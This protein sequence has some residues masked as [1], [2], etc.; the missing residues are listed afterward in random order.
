MRI[1]T[2][3]RLRAVAAVLRMFR[4]QTA[5]VHRLPVILQTFEPLPLPLERMVEVSGRKFTLL[6]CN[7]SA[8][9]F[10]SPPWV[11]SAHVSG[12]RAYGFPLETYSEAIDGGV[13]R[14]AEWAHVVTVKRSPFDPPDS[15]LD[16]PPG[17]PLGMAREF[18]LHAASQ[19]MNASHG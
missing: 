3:L 9:D 11:S 19:R 10:G 18:L 15:P 12:Q 2:R 8:N 13:A 4:R 17:S 7:P 1:W 6:G 14:D 5:P 16:S